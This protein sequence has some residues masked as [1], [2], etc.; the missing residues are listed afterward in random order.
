MAEKLKVVQS[1]IV[2]LSDELSKIQSEIKKLKIQEEL[3]KEGIY[4]LYAE[5]IAVAY[6]EKSEPFGT[7]SFTHNDLKITF[8]TPKKVSWDQEGLAEL[9]KEGA[10][11]KVEY[12][13]SETL[14]KE[15]NDAGKAAFMPYRTVKPGTTSVK[16]EVK[17]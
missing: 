1:N 3:V 4:A 12:G 16:I 6:K 11:V 15:L 8:D 9:Y 14:Y 2:S 7:V 10:P 5:N 17:T 13:V